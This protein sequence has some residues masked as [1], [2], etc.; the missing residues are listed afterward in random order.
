[1]IMWRIK[2]FLFRL[3]CP[4]FWI[5][6]YRVDWDYDSWLKTQLENDPMIT[7]VCHYTA[8]INGTTVWIGNYPYA[9]GGI[10]M[11]ADNCDFIP[12]PLTR[13]MLRKAVNKAMYV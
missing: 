9:Y 1:M 2:N 11:G 3:I 7:D 5:D 6:N 10:W 12:S 4:S 13:V 8:K